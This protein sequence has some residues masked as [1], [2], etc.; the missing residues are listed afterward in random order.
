MKNVFGFNKHYKTKKAEERFINLYIKV[1]TGNRVAQAKKKNV[2]KR[3][4]KK[5]KTFIEICNNLLYF[6]KLSVQISS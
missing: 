5:K 2:K 1:T 3:K 6:L 4:R